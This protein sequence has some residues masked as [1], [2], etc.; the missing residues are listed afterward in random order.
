MSTPKNAPLDSR[1]IGGFARRSMRFDV[2]LGGLQERSPSGP[3]R[4]AEPPPPSLQAQPEPPS[5]AAPKAATTKTPR[6]TSKSTGARKAEEPAA[7]P[8]A[9]PED[10]VEER[11]HKIRRNTYLSGK[12]IEP[13]GQHQLS[14]IFP[15]AI[16]KRRD[17]R[18]IPNDYARS[19]LFTAGSDRSTPRRTLLREKLFHYNEDVTIVYTGIELRAEDDE[20]VWMQILQYSQNVPLGKTFDFS[21][22]DL[23]RDV[24]WKKN[25]A[26]YRRARECISRLKANEVLANNERAYGKSGSM[27]L[28]HSYTATN[29]SDGEQVNF[30]VHIDTNMILLFAGH[31]FTSHTWELYRDLSPIARRLADYM[32]SHRHPYPLDCEKFRL[33]CGSKN[34]DKSSWRQKVRKAC[35]ELLTAGLAAFASLDTKGSIV[36]QQAPPGAL[37]AQDDGGATAGA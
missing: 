22:K 14:L 6:R 9:A 8:P 25:G 17:M 26:N 32:Q 5:P 20:L 27:S 10:A 35:E 29:D 3:A 33:M 12:G 24:G 31:T 28:I 18:H 37:R 23:V 13:G 30:T 11:I 34:T 4:R 1:L 21:L 15:D 19:S 7:P 16:G 2:P 36:I